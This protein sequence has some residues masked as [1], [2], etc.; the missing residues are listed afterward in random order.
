MNM[1]ATLEP[2]NLEPKCLRAHRINA[3]LSNFW[4]VHLQVNIDDLF[5]ENQQRTSIGGHHVKTSWCEISQS[6]RE[7]IVIG[8]GA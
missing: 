1:E 5:N 7:Q 6:K 4:R 3:Q 2:G 8:I